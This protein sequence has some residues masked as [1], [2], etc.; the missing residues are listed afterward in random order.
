V[1]AVHV[2][3]NRSPSPNSNPGESTIDLTSLGRIAYTKMHIETAEIVTEYRMPRASSCVLYEK[4]VWTRHG[5]KTIHVHVVLR[6]YNS[7]SVAQ[8]FRN[9]LQ[10]DLIWHDRADTRFRCVKDLRP[11][12]T[13]GTRLSLETTSRPPKGILLKGKRFEQS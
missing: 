6:C 5:C 9:S 11:K 13:E 10:H 4:R 3:M 2:K 7:Q 12:R 1:T 8:T